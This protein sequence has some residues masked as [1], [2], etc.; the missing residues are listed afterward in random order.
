M[1]EMSQGSHPSVHAELC[2][3]IDCWRAIIAGARSIGRPVCLQ[4]LMLIAS[5]H[6]GLCKHANSI[7]SRIP[8]TA[9]VTVCV[10][11][12]SPSPLQLFC[13]MRV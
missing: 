4:R 7:A 1:A 9:K 12:Y 13:L 11:F 8:L 10:V 2:T 5:I 3:T 6:L